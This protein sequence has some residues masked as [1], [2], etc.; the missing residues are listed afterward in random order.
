MDAHEGA[1]A[2]PSRGRRRW[3]GHRGAVRKGDRDGNR[4]GEGAGVGVRG[5]WGAAGDAARTS[6]AGEAPP[7]A[8]DGMVP[9]E[10]WG[11]AGAPPP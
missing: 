3:E 6:R 10:T 7:G 11:S 5:G 8:T 9:V 4:R 1:R 2:L